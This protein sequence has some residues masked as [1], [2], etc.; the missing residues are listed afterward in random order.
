MS[1]YDVYYKD[2]D[3]GLTFYTVEDVDKHLID[4]HNNLHLTDESFQDIEVLKSEHWVK[5]VVRSNKE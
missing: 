1:T 4:Q 2:T 3:G 5:F